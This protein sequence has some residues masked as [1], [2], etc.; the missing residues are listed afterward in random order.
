VA[1]LVLYMSMSL[2]GYIADSNKPGTGVVPRTLS[3]ACR[4][5]LMLE[6]PGLSAASGCEPGSGMREPATGL[7][8][9]SRK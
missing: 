7:M 4:L 8:R 6:V 3:S 9:S 2:D 1:A 5:A